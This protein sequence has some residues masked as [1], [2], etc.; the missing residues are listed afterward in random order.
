MKGL[1]VA[2][3]T[4]VAV[5]VALGVSFGLLAA[6]VPGEYAAVFGLFA[7]ALAGITVSSRLA[8][9]SATVDELIGEAGEEQQARHRQNES[10]DDRPMWTQEEFDRDLSQHSAWTL[11]DKPWWVR[12]G[13][14]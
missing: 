8:A 1:H 10:T 14:R 11:G 9:G 5:G 13:R 7:A 2:A 4:V 6:G 12:G 3:G